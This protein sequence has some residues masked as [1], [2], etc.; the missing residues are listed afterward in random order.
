MAELWEHPYLAS[1]SRTALES[2]IVEPPF[3]P[4]LSSPLDAVVSQSFAEEDFEDDEGFLDPNA[5]GSQELRDVAQEF[6]GFGWH[7][8]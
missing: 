5:R 1:V 2:R 6:V 3:M 8:A 4:S 7:D